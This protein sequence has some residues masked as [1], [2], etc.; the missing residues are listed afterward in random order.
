M[1]A[2]KS[3]ALALQMANLRRGQL[4]TDGITVRHSSRAIVS[5]PS[6]SRPEDSHFRALPDTY[7]NLSIHTAPDVRTA[8]V[9]NFL[10][11]SDSPTLVKAFMQIKNARLRQRIV[12]L[13]E[14]I[15]DS[16]ED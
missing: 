16:H 12:N 4:Q 6:S 2:K 3:A 5:T 7:V 9:S 11:T 10:S 8:C 13:V 14:Q 1:Q 15:V